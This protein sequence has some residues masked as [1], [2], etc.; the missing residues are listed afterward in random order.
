MSEVLKCSICGQII[1][2]SNDLIILQKALFC[3]DNFERYLFCKDC[4]NKFFIKKIIVQ[5][6]EKKLK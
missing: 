3:D 2:Q 5:E 1:N 6:L 4:Y